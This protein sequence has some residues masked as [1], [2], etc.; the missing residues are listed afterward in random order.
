MQVF[1]DSLITGHNYLWYLHTH[2]SLKTL[3]NREA[4]DAYLIHEA[5]LAVTIS[6]NLRVEFV[7]NARLLL[8]TGDRVAGVSV[9]SISPRAVF[10]KSVRQMILL[11]VGTVVSSKVVV[12]LAV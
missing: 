8:V 7:H 5:T 10:A 2:G 6:I 3:E 12:L 4:W 11:S 1:A 9:V